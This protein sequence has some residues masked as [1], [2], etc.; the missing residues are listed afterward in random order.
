MKQTCLYNR[1]NIV[2]E[3]S[4]NITLIIS[5]I[6]HYLG[7]R[8][9]NLYLTSIPCVD[10]DPLPLILFDMIFEDLHL[11]FIQRQMIVLECES[12]IGTFAVGAEG[13]NLCGMQEK[14]WRVG[15]CQT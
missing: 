3:H 4:L 5:F 13:K 15:Y 10:H 7:Y 14:L 6:F 1:I 11:N 9:L 12:E 2:F 8:L